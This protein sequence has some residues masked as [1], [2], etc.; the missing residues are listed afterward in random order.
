M[1]TLPSQ[2]HAITRQNACILESDGNEESY[3][4][5]QFLHTLHARYPA[6]NYLQYADQLRDQG[7]VHLINASRYG[8]SFYTAT[9]GMDYGAAYLFSKCIA[10]E[11]GK[12]HLV[13]ERPQKRARITEDIGV[14]EE[15]VLSAAN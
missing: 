9:I 2:D 15:N 1:Q 12:P 7:V 8:V 10:K 3:P 6:L 4:I 5:N 14:S 13:M 11:M